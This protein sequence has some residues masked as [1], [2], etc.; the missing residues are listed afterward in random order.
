MEKRE[1]NSETTLMWNNI[2]ILKLRLPDYCDIFP[3][4]IAKWG[5]LYIQ[6]AVQFVA[7]IRIKSKQEMQRVQDE[8]YGNIQ[9][10]SLLLTTTIRIG[11]RVCMGKLFKFGA[12]TYIN[13]C[14]YN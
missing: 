13:M 2:W 12:C 7:F 10:N 4:S 6:M 8:R 1:F 9:L 5:I 14:M 3:N 11:T